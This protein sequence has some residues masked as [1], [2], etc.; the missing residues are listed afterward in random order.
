MWIAELGSQ[1]A[2]RPWQGKLQR[3]NTRIM[4]PTKFTA[5]QLVT[6]K[7]FVEQFQAA[8]DV[9]VKEKLIREAAGNTEL[10]DMDDEALEKHRKVSIPEPALPFPYPFSCTCCSTASS[11]LA[12]Q[13]RPESS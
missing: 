12:V 7:S 8:T 4:A 3:L 10:D 6:L 2:D 13:Q 5:E 1:Q 11:Q 9:K